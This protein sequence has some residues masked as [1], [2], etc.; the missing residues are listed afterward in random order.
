MTTGPVTTGPVTTGP[1]TT[2][3]V[4]TR[5]VT[6]RPVTTR[7]VPCREVS[8]HAAG[9]LAR[10]TSDVPRYFIEAIEIR[11]NKKTRDAV[12]QA[13]LRV[14]AG[15]RLRVD[16]PR[17]VVSRY[18]I[19][20]L[21]FFSDVRLRLKKGSRRGNVILVVRVKERGTIVLSDVFLGVSEATRAWG[22]LGLA[23]KNFLGR[24][25]ALEG[26]FVLGADPDV[27]RGRIQQAYWARL[28][29]PWGGGPLELSASFLYL[30]GSEF[31]RQ[32]GPEGRASPSDFLS[33]PYQRIGGTV[34]V[35]FD[36][37]RWVRMQVD[38]RG[39]AI[40]SSIPAGAVW[41]RPDGR[42]QPIRF[43]IESGDSVLSLISAAMEYD[44]R[45]DPIL[46]SD[47]SLLR[48]T[49][50][51]STR[52]FGSNYSYV[53]LSVNYRRYF[54]L[55][56]GHVVALGIFGG[57]IFGEAPFFEKFF[58]GDLSDL[59]PGRSLGLNFSTLPS[60]DAFGT[61]IDG[62][63]YESLAFMPTV[64]Y[65]IPWFRGGDFAY[66]GD[67]FV[68]AGIFFLGSKDDLRV[69]DRPLSESIP[70]DL[71]IDAGLRLDTRVGIFRVS[72]GNGLGRIPF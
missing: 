62:K 68:R 64:E 61:N 56:W 72:I 19:L 6:T 37:G 16:D 25:I 12:I 59:V 66:A 18:R 23:E 13:A 21:G 4:T 49:A 41:R 48:I 29:A 31:F 57:V 53:K 46:P 2:R 50:D 14:R 47:G 11:G 67:F 71:T 42:R 1:V 60:R 9:A 43:D 70:V 33:T 17:F 58:I 27:E 35:G 34:G 22:G 69:R 54:S 39:E 51:L 3:P 65:S 38:Y 15:E 63:R 30:R 26:A 44:S 7:P 55:P 5:P 52:L 36:I 8:G 45:S 28:R 40:T 10:R 24:G 20:A 32:S